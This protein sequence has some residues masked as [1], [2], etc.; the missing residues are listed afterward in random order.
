MP[1]NRK[2]KT[3]TQ[4]TVMLLVQVVC[5][6]ILSLPIS[7]QN[8]YNEMTQNYN[9]TVQQQQQQQVENLLDILFVLI[10]LINTVQYHFFIFTL[11]GKV[12]RQEL[13]CLFIVAPAT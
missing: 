3:S 9:K 11:T 6:I 5:S 4:M 12:F 1:N 10:T 8:I 2:T 7:I 13:K